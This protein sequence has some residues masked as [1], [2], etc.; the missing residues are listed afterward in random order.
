MVGRKR[1]ASGAPKRVTRATAA[2]RNALVPEVV[3]DLL[4]E[5]TAEPTTRSPDTSERAPKRRKRPGERPP[6]KSPPKTIPKP[7]SKDDDDDDDD[8]DIEFEDVPAPVIQTI[9]REEDEDDDEDIEF[10]DVDIST[11]GPSASSA[12]PASGNVKE[13]SLNLTA[14][15]EA[16][17][18]QRAVERRK[19]ISREE[20][21]RRADIHKMHILCLLSHVERR[22]WWC[23]DTKVQ[24]ILKP[25]LNPKTIGQ[26]N[27]RPSLN[28]FGKT[29][30]LKTGLT[31]ASNVFRAKFRITERGMRRALWPED[32]EQLKDYKLP[33]DAETT[34]DKDDFLEAAMSLEGSRDVGAQLFCALLRSVGL[35]TRLVCSL[36]PLP[37]APGAPTRPKPG[38]P[39]KTGKTGTTP[40]KAFAMETYA[41][42]MA[43]YETPSPPPSAPG[44]IPSIRRRLG[45][46][47]LM[48]YRTPPTATPPPPKPPPPAPKRIRD[49]SPYPIYWVEV[50][51]VAH[52]SWHP[53]DPL[54]TRTQWRPHALEPPASDRENNMS[55]VV[56]FESDSSARDVTRRYV[57]A[58]NA[59]TK[60]ARIDGVSLPSASRTLAAPADGAHPTITEGE[61]W[62]RLALR[63][64]RRRPRTDLD[65]IEEGQLLADEAREPMPRG[66]ADFKDHPIYALERHLRRHEV[67]IPGAEPSGT[68]AAGSKAPLERIY[69]RRDVR[70]ARSRERWYR[71]GRVIKPGEEAVRILAKPQ[72]RKSRFGGSRDDDIDEADEDDDDAGGLFGKAEAMGTPIYT[73]EQ[74]EL[75]QPPPVVNGRVPRNRFGNLDVYVPSMVPPGGAYVPHER[76]AWA[77]FVLGVDYAPALTGFEFKGRQGTAVIKGAVVPEECEEGVK[78]VIEALADLEAEAEEERRRRR[79]LRTWSRFLKGLRIRER[80]YAGVEDEDEDEGE[81]G[82]GGFVQDG[83]QEEGGGFV[84]DEGG[85]FLADEGGGFVAEERAV[86]AKGKGKEIAVDDEDDD[87]A[88]MDNASSAA[89]EVYYMEDED[90]EGGG[91]FVVE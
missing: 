72:R 19:A 73:Y 74:T 10:E 57:K 62:W 35:K 34:H 61:R 6:P 23:N 80:V 22:N 46:A 16:M 24:A 4:S 54:V 67:L 30:S 77:A 38:K 79:A 39:G 41:A 12:V 21:E 88:F 69:R 27:P 86:D 8:D 29:E 17:T 51:N 63:R 45:G 75:Y 11:A 52:Q 59:K 71:L 70:I 14:Q 83:E 5:V 56:A 55:Y 64:Y 44:D 85:G 58:Y 15:K 47:S 91:G 25:L 20:K 13:L 3:R 82:G 66:V 76:A 31:E 18:S 40:R 7:P 68:V 43:K 84:Q 60:R 9:T 81:K 89:S 1:S 49:E 33:D 42:N 2:S 78:A 87:D 37:C 32:E 65:R 28:Q 36:Q 53:V 90:D 50:L 48:S 26:L